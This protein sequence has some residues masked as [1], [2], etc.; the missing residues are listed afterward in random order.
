MN[1]KRQWVPHFAVELRLAMCSNNWRFVFLAFDV[2]YKYSFFPS[3]IAF[4]LVIR[5]YLVVVELFNAFSCLKIVSAWWTMSGEKRREPGLLFCLL[6]SYRIDHCA[7]SYFPLPSL[8]TTQGGFCR[9]KTG[10]RVFKQRR[11]REKNVNRKLTFLFLYALRLPQ[12]YC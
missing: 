3:L 12:L 7:L 10:I 4:L 11:F 8:L 1:T 5:W 2:I 9:W 6:H